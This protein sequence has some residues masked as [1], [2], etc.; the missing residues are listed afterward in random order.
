MYKKSIRNYACIIFYAYICGMR[1]PK[2][3]TPTGA[4]V[5]IYH[6]ELDLEYVHNCSYF[7]ITEIVDGVPKQTYYYRIPDSFKDD[8]LLGELHERYCP[9]S[10]N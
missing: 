9:Y 6:H 3:S 8:R 1:K 2:R 5:K 7:L 4:S 10:P